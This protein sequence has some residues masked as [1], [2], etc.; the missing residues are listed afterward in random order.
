MNIKTLCAI[1]LIAASMASFA[2]EKPDFKAVDADADGYISMDE[3][4]VVQ[5]LAG[6]FMKSDVDNDGKLNEAEYTESR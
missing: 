4:K 6:I 5:G 1:A 3:A 2:S